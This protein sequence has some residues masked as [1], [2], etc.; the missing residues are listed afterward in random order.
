M[1]VNRHTIRHLAGRLGAS[2]PL[3]LHTH[4]ARVRWAMR[5]PVVGVEV[6][7]ENLYLACVRPGIGRRSLVGTGK[8]AAF[9]GLAVEELRSQLRKILAQW[10][11]EDPVVVVGWPRRDVIVRHLDLPAVAEKALDEALQLQLSLFKPNDD[12]EFC[13]DAVAVRDG[14]HFAASLVLLPRAGIENLVAKFAEAGC[15]VARLTVTQFALA[16]LALRGAPADRPPRFLLIHQR[17]TE[18]EFVAVQAGAVVYS[19]SLSLPGDGDASAAQLSAAIEQALANL[20][21]TG[22][23]P[24]VTA[25]SLTEPTEEALARLG[26]VQRASKWLSRSDVRGPQTEESWGAVALAVDGGDWFAPYRL[27]LLP[28]ELRPRRRHWGY[29]PTYGLVAVNVLLLLALGLR[30]P[31]Q[32]RVLLRQY[33]SAI[34]GLQAHASRSEQQIEKEKQLRQQL[35]MMLQF[36]EQG[37]HP[38]DLLSDVASKLPADAWLN[39]FTYHAGQVEID[40][41]AKSASAVLSSLQSLTDVED[42]RFGGALTRD[43]AGL[44]HFRIQMRLKEQR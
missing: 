41:S 37:R 18:V 43:S 32:R 17:G 22:S 19:R 29:L 39:F 1:F 6:R 13:S 26:P 9:R 8:I 30:A 38:L 4:A 2:R 10:G 31:I 5:R 16:D 42:V 24:V 33:R 44:E 21:W 36:Q 27:N 15:P 40:G 20:R 11:A 34:A 28:G 14:D 23:V 35:A 12:V 3:R 25:G 7:G